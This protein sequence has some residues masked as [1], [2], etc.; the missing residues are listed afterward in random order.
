MTERERGGGRMEESQHNRMI[1]I[2]LWKVEK[3]KKNIQKK[4]N[5][6]N[7]ELLSI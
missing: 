5:F 4:I 3:M 7:N 1:Y 6:K 2:A